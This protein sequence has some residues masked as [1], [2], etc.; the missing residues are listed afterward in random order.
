MMTSKMMTSN[1]HPQLSPNPWIVC[2]HASPNPTLRLFCFPYA[3]GGSAIFR[4]W[5]TYLSTHFP[6]L[7]LYAI[8]PPGREG[9]IIQSPIS[10]LPTLV[11]ALTTAILPCLTQPFAFFG[12]SMGGLIAF[13]LA[14]ALRRHQAPQA[15]HLFVSGCR[16][17]QLT[18]PE[19]LHQLP[20]NQ[21]IAELRRYNGTP[22]AVL[23]HP[24]LMELLLPT[25][26]ADFQLVETYQYYSEPALDCSITAFSGTADTIVDQQDVA[27]WSSQ[28]TDQF[29]HYLLPGDHFFIHTAQS[30]LISRLVE[31]LM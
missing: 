18:Y 22:E 5:T 23:N 4:P 26:R 25:I 30:E 11:H 10:H 12:H 16:A 1:P 20:D 2:L 3:G 6:H 9:R 14:R 24:E 8:Q 17:A 29:T 13:E 28:T 7:E 15:S 19:P 21:L 31:K 27:D